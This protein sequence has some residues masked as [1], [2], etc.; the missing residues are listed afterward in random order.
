MKKAFLFK[1]V[2]IAFLFSIVFVTGCRTMTDSFVSNI[3]SDG[4]GNLIIEKRKVVYNKFTGL[5][6]SGDIESSYTIYVESSDD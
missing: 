2:L 5:L 1:L 4:K 6:E 3:T